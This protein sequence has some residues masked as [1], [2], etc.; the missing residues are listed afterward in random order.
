VNAQIHRL[1]YVE[2]KFQQKNRRHISPTVCPFFQNIC[3][4]FNTHEEFSFF[5]ENILQNSTQRDIISMRKQKMQRRK[6]A[7]TP[8]TLA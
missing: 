5:C 2:K 1:P 8:F 4:N 3:Q 7:A 6:D